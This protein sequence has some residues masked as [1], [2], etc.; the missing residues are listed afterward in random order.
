MRAPTSGEEEGF[1]VLL[2]AWR[3]ARGQSQLALSVRTGVS[4]RHLSYME[5][6]RASPSRD[7]VLA[8]AQALEVPLRDR[9]ALLHA[10]GFAPIYRET[11]LDAPAMG[12]VRDAVQLLLGATEPNPT[13]MVNRRYDVLDANATGHW[14]L[15]TFTNDLARFK[16]PYNMGRLLVSPMGMRPHVENWEDVARKVLGR[17]RRELG[18]AHARDAIDDALMKEIGPTLEELGEPPADGGAPDSCGGAVP[19]RRRRASPLHDDRDPRDT[20]GRDTP[21]AA[22]R[23]ALSGRRREQAGSHRT[24]LLT[25]SR[26]VRCTRTE[27]HPG[28]DRAS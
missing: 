8:L 7:M 20:S 5:T 10:A 13:F 28:G 22:R 6:G 4:S 14:L 23:D 19:T 2:R 21:G 16:R 17:L 15:A 18:G 24:Y 3:S 11:P 26:A 1:G 9:N 27:V 12:P 25:R